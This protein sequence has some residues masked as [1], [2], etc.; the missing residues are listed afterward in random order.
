MKDKQ[1]LNKQYFLK[2]AE[3]YNTN[4]NEAPVNKFEYKFHYLM[5]NPENAVII[6]D[7]VSRGLLHNGNLST[8]SHYFTEVGEHLFA[9]QIDTLQI[10]RTR[11]SEY[12]RGLNDQMP[13]GT[14]YICRLISKNPKIRN[15]DLSFTS[16][17][18]KEAVKIIAA[19]QTNTRLQQLNLTGN[20]ISADV[21]LVINSK[22]DA[23]RLIPATCIIGNG[24]RLIGQSIRTQTGFF[25]GLPIEI[26]E[27][28]ATT[29]YE[30]T[31]VTVKEKRDIANSHFSKPIIV[32]KE[33]EKTTPDDEKVTENKCI[34]S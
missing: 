3:K 28:I 19:L 7:G 1:D 34:I 12:N 32:K 31:E 4:S 23:N 22:I 30:G 16:L 8:L 10:S 2:L 25:A 33:L 11:L 13:D 26:N 15:I 18:D 20:N 17:G 27:Q 24:S 5:Q 9:K 14:Q 21:L 6:F 29:L